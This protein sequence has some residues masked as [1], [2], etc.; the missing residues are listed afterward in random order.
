MAILIDTNVLLRSVQ[1][2][3]PM[4]ASAVRALEN[5]MKREEALAVA[6]QNVAEFWI[7]ATRPIVNSG[8][9]FTIE[10]AREEMVKIDAF[11]QIL[12]ENAASYAAWK[13]LI[14]AKRVS[15]VLVHD[16]RLVAVMNT[17]SVTQIVTFNV[18]D[19]SRFSEIEAV[20]PEDWR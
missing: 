17:Y 2:S 5:L 19:F 4:H 15:G 12:S 18:T 7:V 9:G 11:F 10:E 3:N 16:A 6:I 1:P 20:H 14:V 13:A 8:L